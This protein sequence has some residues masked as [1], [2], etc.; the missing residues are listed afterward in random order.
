MI[1]KK[2][3]KGLQQ[4]R[5]KHYLSHAQPR[6]EELASDISKKLY[7]NLL[8]KLQTVSENY[9]ENFEQDAK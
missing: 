6:K 2:H 7:K 4:K 5:Q 9:L 3:E 8:T 1:A